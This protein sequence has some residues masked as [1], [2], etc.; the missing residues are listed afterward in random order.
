MR[1]ASA[2]V[3]GEDVMTLEKLREKKG[4]LPGP[5]FQRMTPRIQG[6][7]VVR[8]GCQHSGIGG[9]GAMPVCRQ[10]KDGLKD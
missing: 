4:A 3:N 6:R 5:G 2:L 7:A 1:Y 10:R 9:A 8:D